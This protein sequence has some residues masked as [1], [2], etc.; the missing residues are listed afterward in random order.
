MIDTLFHQPY[1]FPV[2]ETWTFENPWSL[3]IQMSLSIPMTLSW[4]KTSLGNK[5]WFGYVLVYQTT[6]TGFAFHPFWSLRTKEQATC[7]N[8]IGYEYNSGKAAKAIMWS[9]LANLVIQQTSTI[10]QT[11]ILTEVQY[12]WLLPMIPLSVSAFFISKV[13]MFIKSQISLII[14]I[15]VYDHYKE[16]CTYNLFKTHLHLTVLNKHILDYIN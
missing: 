6:E 5:Y 3:Q 13:L 11:Y 8:L 12:P 9:L 1:Y 4:L 7:H 16:Y 10:F 15:K 14:F 2:L